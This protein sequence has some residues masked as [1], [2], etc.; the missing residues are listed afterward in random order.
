MDS[1]NLRQVNLNALPVLREILRQ[2]NITKA[3]EQLNLS[4]PALSNT[5]RQL[6]EYFKD[7]LIVRRGREMVLTSK[8]STL[9]EPLDQVLVSLQ[10][11]LAD[12]E[13]VAATSR[14]NFEAAMTDHAMTLLLPSL[15]KIFS[16]EAPLMTPNVCSVTRSLP[17]EFLA[18]QTNLAVG[19]RFTSDTGLFSAALLSRLR[20]ETLWI[21]PM[22]CIS[23]E[24]DQEMTAGLTLEEY[25]AY[26]HVVF[27]LGPEFHVNI[28][29]QH[30]A[31]NGLSQNACLHVASHVLMPELVC[32]TRLIALVPL[33]V[34]LMAEHSQPIQIFAP[35]IEF[36]TFEVAISWLD[37]DDANAGLSWVRNII[38]RAAENLIWAGSDGAQLRSQTIRTD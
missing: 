1:K 20:Y 38:I 2:Q 12:D 23:H 34:A 6:R 33:S 36:P 24:D 13:F 18:R 11:L 35:P 14:L 27:D 22:V 7:E 16:V 28:E 8:A 30:L 21:E 4:P 26:P 32:A 19:P 15:A 5:L 9:L 17:S 25:L 37:S 3:A 29:A 10:H 31:A